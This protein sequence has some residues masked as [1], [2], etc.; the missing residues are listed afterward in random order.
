M[1]FLSFFLSF[2]LTFCYILVYYLLYSSVGDMVQKYFDTIHFDMGDFISKLRY[3]RY[4]TIFTRV[5]CTIPSVGVRFVGCLALTLTAKSPYS[6]APRILLLDEKNARPGTSLPS[7]WW[8]VPPNYFLRDLK[9]NC[10]ET[11]RRRKDSRICK[12]KV[13]MSVSHNLLKCPISN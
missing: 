13:Y 10:R 4:D 9:Q 5:C 3:F 6:S 11:L 8:P 2:F 12:V 7:S 1:F